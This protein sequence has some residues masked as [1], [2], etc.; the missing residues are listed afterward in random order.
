MRNRSSGG[1]GGGAAGLRPFAFDRSGRAGSAG[2]SLAAPAL[3]SSAGGQAGWRKTLVVA[4]VGL[5]LLLL[6]G[7]GLFV[8]GLSNLK[9]VN[10]GF[11]VN[12]LL[13]FSVDPALSGYKADRAKLFYRQLTHDLAAV[14]GVRSAAMWVVPPL[15]FSEWDSSVTAEGYVAKPGEDMDPWVNHVSP[16]FFATLKIPLH[17][18]RDFTEQDATGAPRVAIVNEKFARHYFGDRGAVGRHIGLGSDPGTKTSME[19]IGV[20]GDTKYETVRAPIPRQVFFPYLQNT[21]A[22]PMTAYV[23]TELG[24]FQ[25]LPV[26]R[27]TVRK[28]DANLPIYLMKTEERQRDDSLSV[29]K[30]AAIGLYGVMAFLVARRTREIGIRMAFGAVT[31][32]VVRLVVREILL[33]V[34]IGVAIG[35]AAALALTRL[36]ASQLYDVARSDPTTIVAAAFGIAAMAAVSA[37]IPARRA[38]RVDPVTSLRYE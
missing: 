35:V 38:T 20:V 33:L 8:R 7:A 2:I 32:N 17:A 15:S 25:M 16:G 24:P 11:D 19:I 21:W 29:E 37:Y 4:Q 30:L 36:L 31:G 28:L 22:D 3:D 26:L 10:P 9:D 14:P 27:T 1:G 12:N 18:G 13:A 34:G 6:I 5:S 23:R